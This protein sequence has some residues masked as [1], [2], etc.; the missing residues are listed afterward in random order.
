MKK[1][2]FAGAL[3]FAFGAKAQLTTNIYN[4]NGTLTSNRTLTLG[5]YSLHFKPTLS[6]GLFISSSGNVGIG[7]TSPVEKLD[8]TGNL[9][10]H[11]GIFTSIH[12]DQA[13]TFSTSAQRGKECRVISG[14]MLLNEDSGSRIFNFLDAP[15]SNIDPLGPTVIFDIEDRAYKSRFRFTA[16]EGLSSNLTLYDKNQAANFSVTDDGNG[17]VSL[18]MPNTNSFVGIGTTSFTD[19]SDI[20]LLSV[21]GNVRARRVKVYT[22][23]ADYVFEDDYCLPTLQEVEQHIEE[24]GHLIDI[25]S[26]EEVELKGIELGEMN[27][28]LLQKIEELTLYVI[29]LNKEVEQLKGQLKE[30]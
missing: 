14:G 2:I 12:A 8:I 16:I 22:S 25:P 28:L 6:N 23:W 21:D 26:A 3:L 7:N 24:K 5:T 20:F 1:I 9:Q 19:G 11:K 10:A 4:T 17:N 13:Y 29:Q 18:V 27:K 30:E 15:Q